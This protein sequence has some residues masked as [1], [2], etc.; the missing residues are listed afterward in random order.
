M[1]QINY[2]NIGGIRVAMIDGVLYVPAKEEDAVM[3]ISGPASNFEIKKINFSEVKTKGSK[4]AKTPKPRNGAIASVSIESEG[5]KRS[6][7]WN[8]MNTGSESAYDKEEVIKAIKSGEKPNSIAARF[9]G[10]SVQTVYNM[11]SHMKHK[12]EFAARQNTSAPIEEAVEETREPVPAP[13]R[14]TIDVTAAR[15]EQCYAATKDLYDGG[16]SI[17]EII[18]ALPAFHASEIRAQYSLIRQKAN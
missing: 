8:S 6:R 16:C 15:R 17:D 18:A 12:D 14:P 5:K 11:R 3:E 10:L 9:P 4:K 2:F 13:V 1:N 7:K